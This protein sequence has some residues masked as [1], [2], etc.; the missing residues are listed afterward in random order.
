MG[1]HG[2]DKDHDHGADAHAH[3]DFDPQPATELSPGEPRSPAWLPVL[4]AGLFLVGGIYFFASPAASGAAGA[5]SASASASASAAAVPSV[6][7]APGP[8]RPRP[9]PSAGGTLIDAQKANQM[10]RDTN[11]DARKNPPRGAKP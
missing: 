9:V 5:G 1:A 2:H 3:D 7:V 10:L 11:G 6:A 4:G 8:P